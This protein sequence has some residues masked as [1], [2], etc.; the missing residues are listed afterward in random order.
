MHERAL[1]RLPAP[2]PPTRPHPCAPPSPLRAADS[3][4]LLAQADTYGLAHLR[5]VC[6]DYI[7]QVSM[8]VCDRGE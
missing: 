7:V 2:H 4:T 5:S 1:A 3:A 6:L 8:C